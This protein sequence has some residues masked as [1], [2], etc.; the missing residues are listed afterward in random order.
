M[1]LFACLLVTNKANP[2]KTFY[3]F[4]CLVILTGH[5][6]SQTVKPERSWRFGALAGLPVAGK[7]YDNGKMQSA[8]GLVVAA[9]L[10]YYFEDRKSGPSLHF[11]PGFTTFKKTETDGEKTDSYYIESRWKWEAIH[12]PLSFRYTLPTGA[13]RPFVELGFNFQVQNGAFCAEV[14]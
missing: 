8:S 9:D 7:I 4:L 3:S 6:Q 10:G 5:A 11:Q 14:R 2:M 1:S 13:V 12:L